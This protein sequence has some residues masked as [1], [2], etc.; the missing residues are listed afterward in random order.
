[1]C[2]ILLKYAVRQAARTGNPPLPSVNVTYI[3]T[4]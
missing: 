3:H 1:M 2:R 4:Y